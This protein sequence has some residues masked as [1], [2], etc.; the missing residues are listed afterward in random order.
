MVCAARDQGQGRVKLPVIYDRNRTNPG[1]KPSWWLDYTVEGVRVREPC[2]GAS[3]REAHEFAQ[4]IKRQVEEGKWVP[5]LDRKAGK[6]LFATYAREVIDRRVRRGVKGASTDELGHVDNHLAKMFDGMTLVDVARFK[7]IR[8]AFEGLERD[9]RIAGRTVRNIYS[10][11]RS[12]LV[13]AMEDE[14]IDRLP[15]PLTARRGHL[16][17][18]VDADPNWRATAVFTRDEVARLL[19]CEAVPAYRRIIYAVLFMAGG[20]V[21]VEV[22]RLKVGAYD[23]T[24]APLHSLTHIAGK[25]G[26]QKGQEVRIVPVHPDLRRWLDWWLDV[27]WA[28]HHGRA[29]N[30]G[31]LLFPTLSPTRLGLGKIDISHGELYKQWKRYDLP[32]TGLRHRRLH[33][34]RRTL[35]SASRNQAVDGAM[36][37]KLTHRAVADVVLDAYTTAE[38]ETLCDEVRRVEWNAPEVPVLRSVSAAELG[39][40]P[41]GRP[42]KATAHP[43]DEPILEVT[44]TS[45]TAEIEHCASVEVTDETP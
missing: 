10:T 39:P 28:I 45:Q 17:P 38:W 6:Y 2:P 21:A 15:A 18:P 1:R 12:I 9:K 14:L 44:D 25:L 33:D 4:R 24:A 19:G 36:V 13:E 29:P 41:G 40:R 30:P 42:R 16:S 23:R 35:V 11:L 22:L 8:E 3:K 34:A 32:A 37:R 27:G 26:R 5:P 7:V 31:D 20:R 43:C